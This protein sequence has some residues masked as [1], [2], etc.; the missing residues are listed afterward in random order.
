MRAAWLSNDVLLTSNGTIES[1]PTKSGEIVDLRT[2]LREHFAPLDAAARTRVI[3]DVVATVASSPASADSRK[4]RR[5]LYQL[6][7][8]LRDRLP[9][10]EQEHPNGNG[11]GKGNGA[12]APAPAAGRALAAEGLYRAD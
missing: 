4:L 12:P 1:F 5:S 6:R 2:L 8:A 11:N 7:E 9:D 3:R 10:A